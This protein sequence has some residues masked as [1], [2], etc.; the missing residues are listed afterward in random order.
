M[1]CC[2]DWRRS[3]VDEEREHICEWMGR[4]SASRSRSARGYWCFMINII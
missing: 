4:V 1:I 3:P 2:P